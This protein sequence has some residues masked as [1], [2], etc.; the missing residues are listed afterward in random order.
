MIATLDTPDTLPHADQREIWQRGF[1][2]AIL[3]PEELSP[4]QFAAK[5]RILH[6]VYCSERPGPWPADAFPYQAHVMDAVE[7]AIHEG[8]NGIVF[9]KGGQ[10]GGTDAMIN[11]M[12]WCKV[13]FPGPQ[14]FMTSTEK[15]AVKFGRDRF[16]NII[17]DMKPLRDKVIP[18]RTVALLKRFTDGEIQLSGGQSVFNLQS[19][20]FRVVGID[21]LDSLVE[22]LGESGDPVKLAEVR[23]D[24]FTGPTLIIAY[25]HPSTKDRGAAK[26]FYEQSDQQRGFVRHECNH[27][28]YW[29]W[30][31]IKPGSDPYDPDGYV[32]ACPGCGSVLTD[33]ERVYMTRETLHYKSVFPP[34]I[35]KKKIWAGVHASQGY[36][37]SKT[38]R[39]FAVRWI[40]SDCGKDD[41]S[42]KVFVNKVWGEP[43]EKTLKESTVEEWRR[44]IVVPQHDKDSEAY[45]KGQVPP[46]V[47]F[48]TA[49]QDS[50]EKEFHYCVWGWGLART[51]KGATVLRRWLIDWDVCPRAEKN[52]VVM[53][54]ELNIFNSLIYER[55]YP[56][57][58]S[59]DQFNVKECAHDTGWNPTAIY[60]YCQQHEHR[61]IPIKGGAD[62]SLSTAKVWRASHAPKY[63]LNGEIREL[64]QPLIVFNTYALKLDWHGTFDRRVE[65]VTAAGPRTVPLLSLP[66]DAADDEEWLKQASTEAM[67]PGKRK[68]EKIFTHKHA[69]HFGDCNIYS[70]GLALKINPFQENETA[71]EAE[72]KE[73]VRAVEQARAVRPRE[74]TE[75]EWLA[76]DRGQQRESWISERY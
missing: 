29:Q 60:E 55:F 33:A 45:R 13:Y 34:E 51:V 61:A 69:N 18:G 22:D 70:Y 24:S 25:A 27:E 64:S 3:P 4:S 59:A 41:A 50:R 38:I 20:P 54:D 44:Q 65:I 11:A 46:G 62:S 31:H 57:T 67:I 68:G 12:L 17:K 10:I 19:N 14:L 15:V 52:E 21:E 48:L 76:T 53:P 36:S 16:H 1:I 42:A 49:G 66:M 63:E 75:K 47:R 39:S 5:H 30:D 43:Y 35:A 23:T 74:R 37:P 73:K 26:L 71:E 32:Y 56:T 58:Y 8:K 28:F 6:K 40:A 72:E 7:R 2:D 9:M